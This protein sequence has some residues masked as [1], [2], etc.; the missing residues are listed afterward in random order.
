MKNPKSS[1]LRKIRVLVVDDHPVVRRGIRNMIEEEA[2]MVV[3]AEGTGSRDTL[4]LLESQEFDVV[5][6]DLTLHQESGFD[7]LEA[8]R[9]KHPKLPILVIS[10]YAEDHAAIRALQAGA[11]G[12]LCKDAM[13]AV[14]I[15]ALRKVVGGGIFVSPALAEQLAL[16]LGTREK[17][18]HE[19]LSPR[20]SMVM[21]MLAMGHSQKQIGENLCLSTK[22]INTFKSRIFQK[23]H[24]QSSADLVK[25]VIKF[26]LL[27]D[28]LSVGSS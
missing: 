14:L 22:T 23:M 28:P 19:T 1:G 27:E 4:S 9:E 6:L 24:F 17:P 10:M 3:T 20:E 25:Y 13:A 12:Y 21:R 26:H 5:T 8:I 15:S 7:V 16:R 18:L 11:A 2:D